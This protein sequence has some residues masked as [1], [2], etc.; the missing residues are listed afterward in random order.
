MTT[1]LIDTA[2]T[3]KNLVESGMP[4]KQAEAIVKAFA[5]SREELATKADLK[6]V[7]ARLALKIYLMAGLVVAGLKLLE[8]LGI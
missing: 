2:E 4:E 8:Y 1:N 5:K 3:Q 6:G 7:E